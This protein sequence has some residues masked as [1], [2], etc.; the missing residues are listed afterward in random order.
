[1]T[2]AV[3]RTETALG[4]IQRPDTGKAPDDALAPVTAALV[5]SNTRN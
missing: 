2:M 4:A 3:F 5:H 1:M